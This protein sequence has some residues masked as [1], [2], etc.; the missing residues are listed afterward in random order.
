MIGVIYAGFNIFFIKFLSKVARIKKPTD[1]LVKEN[2]L[3]LFWELCKATL[4]KKPMSGYKLGRRLG[5][6]NSLVYDYLKRWVKYGLVTSEK[7]GD[8]EYFYINTEVVKLMK[9]TVR[10]DFDEFSIFLKEKE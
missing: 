9:T 8:F 10:I 3:K 1:L 2:S 7:K 6:D 4:R 5:L